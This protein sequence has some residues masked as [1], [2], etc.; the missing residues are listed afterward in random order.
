MFK[1]LIIVDKKK[2]QT[3]LDCIHELRSKDKDLGLLPITYAGRLDPLASGVLLLLVGDECH[4]K[5]EYLKLGKEY[6]VEILFGFAT[7]TCDVMGK[8]VKKDA[9]S[10]EEFKRSSDLLAPLGQTVLNS[11][12]LSVSRIDDIFKQFTGHINQKYPVYSSRP[13]LGKPLFMW[14]RENKLDEIEIP[15]HNVF[16]ENIDLVSSSTITGRKLL[17]KIK[18]DISLVKGDFRQEEIIKLWETNLENKNDEE[19]QTIKIKVRC[20][21]GVYVRV[22]AYDIGKALGTPSLA[23]DINRTKVGEYTV[24]IL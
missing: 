2:G 20:G 15:T 5:D 1:G 18:N 4:K 21:S 10:K 19:F 16:I 11:S 3:P 22:L 12:L 13:V 24:P 7:D 14:A 23:L 6:E 17:K 9:P 8:I